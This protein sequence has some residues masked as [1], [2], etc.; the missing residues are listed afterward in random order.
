MLW[1]LAYFPWRNQMASFN[2]RENRSTGKPWDFPGWAL[3][4]VLSATSVLFPHSPGSVPVHL[5]CPH[6]MEEETL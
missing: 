1:G 4:R 6:F 2:K 5:A 3:S